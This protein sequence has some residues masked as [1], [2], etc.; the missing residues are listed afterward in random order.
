[1]DTKLIMVLAA[2]A[3]GA[4]TFAALRG[5]RG[6]PKSPTLTDDVKSWENEGGNVPAVP[7]PTP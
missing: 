3:A 7:T 2:M 5:K 6:T 4:G 1:M